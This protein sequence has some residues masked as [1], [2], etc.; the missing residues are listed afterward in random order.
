MAKK[1]PLRMCTGCEQ[2]KSKK[3]LI[4][5]VKTPETEIVLDTTGKKNGRGA[6]VCKSTEC[7]QKAIKTRGLERSL[8][9]AIPKEVVEM[10]EEE[11]AN[12]E[13]GEKEGI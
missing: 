4:R 8:R 9:T 6:Y 5:V 10:L 1:I 2:A 13:S 11:M 7:L 3:E 12:F